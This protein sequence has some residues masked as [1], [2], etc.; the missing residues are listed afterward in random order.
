[1]YGAYARSQEARS[2]SSIVGAE[3]LSE[4]DRRYLKFGELFERKFIGQ[5]LYERRTIEETLSVGWDLLSQLPESEL[6]R[7]KEEY[8]KM[9]YK[10]K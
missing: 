4:S 5:G 10:K 8:I 7:I 9:Y 2:L 1:M 3:A 6:S